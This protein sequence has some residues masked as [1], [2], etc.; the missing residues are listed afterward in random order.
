MNGITVGH[1]FW[2]SLSGSPHAVKIQ[3][4]SSSYTNPIT[5]FHVTTHM[6]LIEVGKH[7]DI[8]VISPSLTAGYNHFFLNRMLK[9][10][11]PGET[12]ADWELKKSFKLLYTC[13][14]FFRT[15]FF[16]F[17]SRFNFIIIIISIIKQLEATDRGL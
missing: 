16:S 10:Y 14:F 7:F 9:L 5:P 2:L 6:L 1:C 8:F 3:Y 12:S 11:V 15:S 17:I 4:Q 13:A